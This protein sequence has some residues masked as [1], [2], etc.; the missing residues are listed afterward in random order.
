[1]KKLLVASLFLTAIAFTACE[2][3]KDGPKDVAEEQNEQ[4]LP[5]N[6]EDDA[7][8]AVNAAN[9]GM[10]EVQLGKLAQT[11]AQS[12][13][14]R[15][16]GKMMETDHGAAN[17]KLK[18]IA[19]ANNITLPASL[20]EDAQKHYN[21]LAAKKGPDFDK[22]YVDMM[23]DDHAKDIDNFQEQANDGKNGALKE[24]AA[25][26]LPTLKLHKQ[27]IDAIKAKMK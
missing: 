24:F 7:E 10:L 15:A 18:S 9:G 26:T 22:L 1:M 23:V 12:S 3:K 27:K 4:K 16:F 17:E 2:E 8:F 6:M 25:T 19:A 13:E 11:N 20:G 14:V 21:D 5:D